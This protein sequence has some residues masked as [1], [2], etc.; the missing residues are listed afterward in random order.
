MEKFIRFSALSPLDI[1][2]LPHVTTGA[3]KVQAIL[4]VL[5]S[6]IGS[7]ALLMFVIGGMRYISAQGDPAQISKAKGTLIYALVGVLVS[8]SAVA[9]VTFV[10][11]RLA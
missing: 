10:L 11:G 9:I 8:M 3:A 7:I 6:I 2:P 4:T 1:S 5:F